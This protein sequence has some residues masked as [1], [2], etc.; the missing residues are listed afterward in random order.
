MVLEMKILIMNSSYD[1][2]HETEKDDWLTLPAL[3]LIHIARVS[4]FVHTAAT[5]NPHLIKYQQV[6]AELVKL[7]EWFNANGFRNDLFLTKE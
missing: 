7:H 5:D 3:G 1:F 4:N 6:N 2:K